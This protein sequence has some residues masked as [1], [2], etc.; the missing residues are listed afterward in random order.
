MVMNLSEFRN[1]SS[2][3]FLRRA[4]DEDAR[5]NWDGLSNRIR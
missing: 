1:S 4:L 2:G 3:L 5:E